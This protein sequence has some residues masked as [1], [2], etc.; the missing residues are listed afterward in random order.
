MDKTEKKKSSSKKS[1]IKKQVILFCS[2]CAVGLILLITGFNLNSFFN[3]ERVLGSKTQIEESASIKLAA[4]KEFWNNF[5]Q[6]NPDYFERWVFVFL[7]FFFFFL[8]FFF[9]F[10][11]FFFFEEV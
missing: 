5:L 2:C 4:D 9:F 1:N 6:E 11:F 3:G 7:F 10:F 8:I